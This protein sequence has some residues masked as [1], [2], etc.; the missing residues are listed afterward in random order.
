M[1]SN[2]SFSIMGEANRCGEIQGQPFYLDLTFAERTLSELA[3]LYLTQRLLDLVHD[4]LFVNPFFIRM[5]SHF[6]AQL[7]A[8]IW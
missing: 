7:A 4:P 6:A 1:I 5:S 2:L 3:I 8:D